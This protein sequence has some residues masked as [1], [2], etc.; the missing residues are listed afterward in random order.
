MSKFALQALAQGVRLHGWEHGI[1]VSAICPGTVTTDMTIRDGKA[2]PQATQP[3]TVAHL[4]ATILE[5]PNDTYVPE[6][7][8]AC[9][10]ETGWA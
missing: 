3:G 1:R 4:V 8:I 9:K 10:L 2:P 5:L 6:I 7:G